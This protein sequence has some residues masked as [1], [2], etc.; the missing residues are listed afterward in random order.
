[1]YRKFLDR[2]AQYALPVGFHV[3]GD[4]H[5]KMFDFQREIVRWALWR[6]RAAIF[7]ECG[8]GK[9]LVEHVWARE[10]NRRTGKPVIIFA[11]L[12]VAGQMVDEGKKFGIEVVHARS[13]EDIGNISATNYDRM[14]LFPDANAFGGIVIDEGSILKAY[15]GKTR[16]AII[17]YAKRIPYRLSATATPAPNDYME[18]GNQ[19]EYLDVLTRAEMLATFFTHDGGDTAKWRLKGHAR[20]PFWKWMASWSVALRK[21]SDL[22][23]DDGAFILPPLEVVPIVI[24]DNYNSRGRLITTEAQTLEERRDV[25]RQTITQRVTACAEL[26]AKE[27]THPWLI[28]CN[29]NAEG[30]A[31]E[32]AIPGSVQV[33]GSDD[34]ATKEDY[35][36]GFA[37]GKY[38]V[39]ISKPSIAGFGMNFQRCSNVV[40]VGLSDSWE[41]Y[42]QA[43]RRCWRF[44]QKNPVK[45]YVITCSSEG[46]VVRNI[47]RKEKQAAEMIDGIV[48]D[49]K[50]EMRKSLKSSQARMVE[51]LETAVAK[52][53]GWEAALGDCVERLRAQKDESVGYSIFSPPF[54]S[55]YTYTSSLRDMGNCKND[56]EFFAHFKFLL[57]E[58]LRV[59]KA[60]RLVSMHCMNLTT[61]KSRQGFIGLRDFRGELI[62]AMEKVGFIFHS[63]V[64]IWKDPLVAMQRTK[65]LGLLHKQIV[66]DSSQCRQGVP[67]YL[68]TFRKPGENEKRIEH[69]PNGFARF[70]G[71]DP[72]KAKKDLNPAR[73]KYSHEVWQRYASPVWMDIDPG[74]T[75]QYRAAKENDD[76]RHICP[77]QLQVIERALELWSNPGDLVLSPFAG[78]G[79][80]GWVA[81]RSG[82]RFL[83]IELK[84]SYWELAV[85]NLKYAE[86]TCAQKKLF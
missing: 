3:A 12:A 2:K 32:K 5:P 41:Q 68:V 29:L 20:R 70:V 10:V 51:K 18:L 81:L 55:L 73:N 31:I 61:Q 19:A 65:A 24:D 67:D 72:P 62:W 71:E 13:Q 28:W 9:T 42:Y 56:A 50:E 86:K 34:E 7:S 25:R 78:I 53:E 4:I 60:G 58:L 17:D 84:K 54:S 45:A 79:S 14:H 16:N 47:Q 38:R 77:L 48:A 27:P 82:R 44:G 39:L 80:E 1:M 22:G 37:K 76:E 83:G 74:K 66:K 40:F 49:M 57:P 11:P 63:E 75:L 69:K 33:S 30:D 52:G 43:V 85:K 36:L 26:V 35:L 15:A 59:L 8:T 23:F 21:P 64:C 6:G 46:A